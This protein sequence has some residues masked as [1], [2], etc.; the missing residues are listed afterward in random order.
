MVGGQR[1]RRNGAHSEAM[2]SSRVPSRSGPRAPAPSGTVGAR[3]R[4][5][6][7]E[8]IAVVQAGGLSELLLTLPAVEGLRAAYPSAEVALLTTAANLD[9]LGSRSGPWTTLVALPETVAAASGSRRGSSS[10]TLSVPPVAN[11]SG[12]TRRALELLADTRFDL[13]VQLTIDSRAA[14]D[15]LRHLGA[16][17]SVGTSA[18]VEEGFDRAIEFVP[19]QHTTLRALEIVGLVGAHPAALAPSI[20]VR[21]EDRDRARSLLRPF[22]NEA[23][24]LL[25]LHPGG[26]DPRHRW[27]TGWFGEVAARAATSGWRAVVVG[28][29]RD[30]RLARDVIGQAVSHGADCRRILDLTG[31]TDVSGLIGIIDAADALVGNDSGPLHLAE[32]VGT[33]SV[34]IFWVGGSI[35]SA[36]LSR[37]RHRV[38]IGWTT[39]CPICGKDATQAIWTGDRCEHEPSFVTAVA[40]GPVWDDVEELVAE[41]RREASPQ[42]PDAF[43]GDD[44]GAFDLRD[45]DD[46]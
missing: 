10:S 26:S 13:G 35:T 37:R 6:R 27:P 25:V 4:V 5:D 21:R 20:T 45:L 44:T 3:E 16:R 46:Y 19:L 23:R 30:G 31:R 42:P 12:A 41:T 36:P 24:P 8:R 14:D 29:E 9:L 34:G 32:A 38:H 43:V 11:G 7:V 33:P 15:F 18:H 22:G 17:V 1:S 39:S 2:T 40:V 28:S